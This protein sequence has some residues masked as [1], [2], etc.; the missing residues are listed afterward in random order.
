VSVIVALLIT[1]AVSLYLVAQTRAKP[2][3]QTEPGAHPAYTPIDDI[4]C[5]QME[6]AVFHIHA[7]LSFSLD[8]QA[9]AIPQGIGI[10]PDSS[11]FYWLHTHDASGVI[12]IEAPANRTFTLG[13]FLDIWGQQFSEPRTGYPSA[14]DQ[15]GGPGWQV[16]VNGKPYT[17]DFHM[18]VLQ[19]HLLITLAYHSPGVRPDTTYNWNGRKSC[20]DHRLHMITSWTRTG[21]LTGKPFRLC[22]HFHAT[23]AIL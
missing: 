1:A 23:S 4:A 16:W 18:I 22:L 10:A 3:N 17:G 21:M 7:H 12:H 14:L 20:L 5:N 8:G 13:N 9:V 6:Q 11:C 19:P 15:P 2:Q